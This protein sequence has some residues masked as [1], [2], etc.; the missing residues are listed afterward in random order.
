MD[1]VLR[2][3]AE[4]CRVTDGETKPQR[5]QVWQSEGPTWPL[6]PRPRL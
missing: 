3:L 2:E 4:A 5:G 6:C 1:W